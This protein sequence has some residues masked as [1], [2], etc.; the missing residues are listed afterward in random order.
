MIGELMD[1][2]VV[3]LSEIRDNELHFLSVYDEGKIKAHA[4]RCQ[5]EETPCATVETSKDLRVY[6]NVVDL[7]QNAEFLKRYNAFS[8]CGFP[9]L[10]N[11]GNVVAVICLLDN[12]L[13]EFTEEDQDLLKIFS[14][15]IGFEIERQR[16]QLER[17]R[18]I[19]LSETLRRDS[20]LFIV[21]LLMGY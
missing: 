14:Q 17:Q 19:R 3:C 10:D 2:P 8:Y 1:V 4:G 20:G 11:E 16:Y 7:F 5:L 21:M 13:H 18:T 6:H 9:A 12:K 15:R